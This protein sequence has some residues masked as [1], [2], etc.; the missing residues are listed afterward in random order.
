[1]RVGLVAMS[2]VRAHE[3][4]LTALG[5]TLPG[6]VERS[7][8]IASLPSLGLLTL[9]GATPGG[10]DLAYVDVPDLLPAPWLPG[11]FD[12]VAVSSFS[13]QMKEAYELADRFRAAG[14]KVILG[15][16]HVTA[17]PHEAAA[18]AD[19]VVLGEGE[20]LWPRVVDDLRH[21]TLDQ[22]YDARA[23]S[24]DLSQAP[25]PRYE[26]LD[27]DKY[28]RLTIQTQ[29]GCPYDCEFCAASIRIAPKFKVKPVAMVVDELRRI[30]S[31]WPQ[32]FIELAD[33]NTFANR[34]HGRRLLRAL[35]GEHVRWFTETDLSIAGD[36]ELLSLMRDSGC[37]QVLIGF[38]S[39]ARAPVERV[40]QKTNWKARQFDRYREAVETIQSFGITV[41]GC[42]ILGLDGAGPESFDEVLRF[43]RDSA[44]Y[45]VQITVQTPFPGTPL[46]ERL[47]REGRILREGA[48]ELCT[49]F[50]VNFRPSHMSVAQLEQG[51][52]DLARQLYDAETTR[53]R[54]RCFHERLRAQRRAGRPAETEKTT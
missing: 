38:E 4:E 1:M 8:V 9:A 26:L 33:D 5:L 37:A 42:F 12:A 6:F 40:E 39:A 30:K 50:D 19:A 49:L 48:W 36:P 24:F 31:I 27:V 13:A 41:N 7:R 52:R 32:P 14:T 44:L 43:V 35:A 16:L 53:E 47:L 23:M 17:L 45:E 21:G 20:P 10:V 51:L 28:N 46:Y 54:Q 25:T 11:D 22:V 3:P 18:H 34:E 2:G 15:G 29:R